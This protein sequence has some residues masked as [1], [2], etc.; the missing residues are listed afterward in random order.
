MTEVKVSS[1]VTVFDRCPMRYRV[2]SD[3]VEFSLGR[4]CD[5]FEFM[6]GAEALR[7]FLRAGAEALRELDDREEPLV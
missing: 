1:Y 5:P 4:S 6:F 7:E 2:V 3:H